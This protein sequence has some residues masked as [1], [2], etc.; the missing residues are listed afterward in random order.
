M[1]QPFLAEIKLMSFGFPPKGYAFCDGQLLPINQNQVLFQLLGTT[2]GGDGQTNFALPN[3]QGR[4]PVHAPD[5]NSL[6]QSGGEETT[7][8]TKDQMPQHAHTLYASATSASETDPTNH[9]VAKKAR[10]GK[11]I[12]APAN[13]PVPMASASLVSTGA[14]QPHNNMQPYLT[15]T[16]VIALVGV[17]PSQN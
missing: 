6:G 1:S 5:V 9:V 16:F 10:F 7:S 12:L 14:T 3:L 17:F 15:L 13:N 4:A 8:L 2:Y 11:D